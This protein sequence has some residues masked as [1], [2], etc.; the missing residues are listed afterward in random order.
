MAIQFRR[1]TAA[2][3]AAA[4]PVLAPGEPGFESDTGKQKI[5]TGAAWSATPYAVGV[6][7]AADLGLGDFAGLTPADLPVSTAVALAIAAIPAG[8]GGSAI[9]RSDIFARPDNA[10]TLGT[11]SDGLA[12]WTYDT[13]AVFGIAGGKA[14][15]ASGAGKAFLKFPA[16]AAGQFGAKLFRATAGLHGIFLSGPAGLVLAWLNNG[17]VNLGGFGIPGGPFTSSVASP[18]STFSVTPEPYLQLRRDSATGLT[19]VLIDG[20]IVHSNTFAPGG[21]T[22]D[23]GGLYGDSANGGSA[24]TWTNISFGKEV[25]AAVLA[26]APGEV[27]YSTAWPLDSIAGKYSTR[28]TLSADQL[29]SFASGAVL[30]G[31]YQ[32]EVVSDGTS[33]L[34]FPPGIIMPNAFDPN[35]INLISAVQSIAGPVVVIQSKA[36]PSGPSIVSAIVANASP[37]FVDLQWSGPV[38][39]AISDKSAFGIT[40]HQ[41]STHVAGSNNTR[42]RLAVNEFGAAEARSLNYT[43]PAT[44]KMKGADGLVSDPFSKAITNNIVA[45]AGVLTFGALTPTQRVVNVTTEGTRGWVI[46]AYTDVM[47][48][49]GFNVLETT[50]QAPGSSYQS[51]NPYSDNGPTAVHVNGDNAAAGGYVANGTSDVQTIFS[52]ADVTGGPSIGLQIPVDSTQATVTVYFFAYGGDVSVD[53]SLSDGSIAAQNYHPPSSGVGGSNC[54]AFTLA[55]KAGSANQT[56]NLNVST[57]NGNNLGGYIM[58]MA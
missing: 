58:T 13:G 38:D 49:Q 56:L 21:F 28:Q 42:T 44:N 18:K 12:P 27:P 26:L 8:G 7:T 43:V 35:R 24:N 31:S 19:E 29:V 51:G 23:A 16:G 2:Q 57:A 37:G 55:V 15:L 34:A 22:A 20:V 25:P 17:L 10:S 32:V 5:G 36:I 3:W 39:P 50:A 54:R 47:R 11:P 46:R 41:I 45:G 9:E 14:Y 40:G 30:D 4:N 1:G 6:T 33:L 48:K 52:Y 53:A